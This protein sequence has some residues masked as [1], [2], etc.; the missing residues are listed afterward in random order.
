MSCRLET[1]EG[2]SRPT[3]KG[4]RERERERR[5]N[6]NRS[7]VPL[8]PLFLEQVS[9]F[10]VIIED[11]YMVLEAVDAPLRGAAGHSAIFR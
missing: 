5:G 9:E 7:E 1:D 4:E 8:I 2:H 10:S 11:R 6:L 3:K